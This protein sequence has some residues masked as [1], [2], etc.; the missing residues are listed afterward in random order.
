MDKKHKNMKMKKDGYSS[1]LDSYWFIIDIVKDAF[2]TKMGRVH[3]DKQEISKIQVSIFYW[4]RRNYKCNNSLSR[5][6]GIRYKWLYKPPGPENHK[7]L[8]W[9]SAGYPSDE[10]RFVANLRRALLPANEMNTTLRNARLSLA[11][12]GARRSLALNRMRS[13]DLLRWIST[14]YLPEGFMIFRSW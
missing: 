3:I 10:I 12:S 14:G 13:A 2:G 11:R 5:G 7:S 6:Y 9:I 4:G 8:R 1:K